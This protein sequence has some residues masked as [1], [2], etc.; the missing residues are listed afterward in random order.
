MHECKGKSSVFEESTEEMALLVTLVRVICKDFKVN[1][2]WPA[3]S[4]K[5]LL[6]DW[7]SSQ[8]EVDTVPE[9]SEMAAYLPRNHQV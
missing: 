3:L 5:V 9:Y 4:A 8:P 6:S 1:L 7:I 2:L